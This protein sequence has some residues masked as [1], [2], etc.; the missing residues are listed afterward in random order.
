MAYSPKTIQEMRSAA[1]YP[2]F[3]RGKRS[4]RSLP[5]SWDGDMR[6][7]RPETKSW[8]LY[9]KKQWERG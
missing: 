1:A 8:K 9:R 4:I 2:A 6:K 3:V 7:D 5:S